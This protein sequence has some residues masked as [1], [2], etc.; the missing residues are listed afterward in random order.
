MLGSVSCRYI[1]ALVLVAYFAPCGV[2]KAGVATLPFIG[3]ITR[4]LQFLF[5]ARSGTTGT[6]HRI[7]SHLETRFLD[8]FRD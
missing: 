1:D 2:A 7:C 8:S 5:V 6:A 4:G 3:T